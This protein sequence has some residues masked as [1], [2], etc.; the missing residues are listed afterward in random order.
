MRVAVLAV[1]GT[2]DSGLS[3]ML[4]VLATADALRDDAEAGDQ[5]FT[6]IPVAVGPSVRTR[7]GL[8]LATTPLTE[9]A[10]P[11]DVLVMPAV[12]VKTPD[13]IVDVV[14]GHPALDWVAA[15]RGSGAALAA[16]CSG[17]FFLAPSSTTPG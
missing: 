6:V 15:G 13:R 14:R 8:V 12:G 5:A 9:I 2:F 17:T 10:V 16:A 4:D 7:H 3:V 1:D 11:P